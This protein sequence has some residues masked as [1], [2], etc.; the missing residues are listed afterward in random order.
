MMSGPPRPED[1]IPITVDG[2]KLQVPAVRT[3]AAALMIEGSRAGWRTSRRRGEP[4][5]VFCG[6]GVCY[7]CLATIDG[8]RG[9][10]SC[11]VEVVKGME[12]STGDPDE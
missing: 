11:L 7:E 10:R 5:G 6:I 9:M 12:V 4:R 3:V 2:A 8:R 1:L